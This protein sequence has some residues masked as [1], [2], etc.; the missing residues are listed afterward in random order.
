MSS[1]L[2]EYE[3]WTR[4]HAMD[5]TRSHGDA[6]RMLL[7]R[8]AW[9]ELHPR[10]LERALLPF[11]VPVRTLDAI[12][13]ASA[14]RPVFEIVQLDPV[15]ANVGVPETDVHLVKIGQ[16]ASITFPALP[17]RSFQGTVRIINVAADPATCLALIRAEVDRRGGVASLKRKRSV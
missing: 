16:K 8:L 12:H 14:G 13:L 9:L 2:L 15:E 3:L 10:V 1:R 11:P 4:I 5:L 7:A 6:A 17:N